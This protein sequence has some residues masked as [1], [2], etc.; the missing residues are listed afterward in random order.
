MRHNRDVI[1]QSMF[2]SVDVPVRRSARFRPGRELYNR[3]SGRAR[4]SDR[5]RPGKRYTTA[6]KFTVALH[7]VW[8]GACRSRRL[9]AAVAPHTHRNELT[10]YIAFRFTTRAYDRS[11]PPPP[12]PAQMRSTAAVA[13]AAAEAAHGALYVTIL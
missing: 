9:A 7:P 4:P 8:T 5:S 2:P 11:V 6:T 10:R 1:L 12:R 13:A 3:R